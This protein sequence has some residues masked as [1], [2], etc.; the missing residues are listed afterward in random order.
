MA[1]KRKFGG[2]MYYFDAQYHNEGRA[3]ARA[4]ALRKQ[5]FKAR[6][7]KVDFMTWEVWA[8]D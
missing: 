5:G 6:V 3:Y 8:R 1:L 4:E 2:K 7:K